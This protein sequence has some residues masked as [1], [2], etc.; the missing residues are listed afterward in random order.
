MI[1]LVSH[2]HWVLIA[3]IELEQ[4]I[5]QPAAI[6][7][8]GEIE[9]NSKF[10]PYFKNA[11]GALDRTHIPAHVPA[12]LRTPF[13]NRKGYILQNVLV[14][15]SFNLVFTYGL[16]G[17][18]GSAH[19]GRVLSDAKTKGFEDPEGKYYL[20]DAGYTLRK[21]CLTPYHG[22]RYHLREHYQ[23]RKSFIFFIFFIS[24]ICC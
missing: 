9:K 1:V 16:P 20:A 2:F 21:G 10:F 7:Y 8:P 14:A 11:I 6:E 15:C 18:K 5:I 23:S 17:W 19:D 22:V 12:R 24:C 3:I 13:R 4:A